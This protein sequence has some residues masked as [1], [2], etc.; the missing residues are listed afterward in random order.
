[1]KNIL[2]I[3]LGVVF[4]FLVIVGGLTAYFIVISEYLVALLIVSCSGFALVSALV[5]CLIV[6]EIMEQNVFIEIAEQIQKE[7]SRKWLIFGKC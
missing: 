5:V 3:I 7:E 4:L 6:K 2:R 1:M